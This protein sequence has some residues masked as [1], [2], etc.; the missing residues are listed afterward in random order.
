VSGTYDSESAVEISSTTTTNY[1]YNSVLSS[2]ESETCFSRLVSAETT[3]ES[4]IGAPADSLAM[5]GDTYCCSL[6]M[7]EEAEEEQTTVH[8][9][10]SP[11]EEAITVSSESLSSSSMSDSGGGPLAGEKMT[12][13]SNTSHS[14]P[15]ETEKTT[16]S[17][18]SRPAGQAKGKGVWIFGIGSPLLRTPT[19]NPRFFFFFFLF[20]F[21]SKFRY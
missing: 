14:L 20:C 19:G 2:V 8:L 12:V 18:D 21:V 4:F 6:P 11:F 17:V 1:N 15:E 3:N 10:A 5:E 9:E 7:E 16:I 13:F